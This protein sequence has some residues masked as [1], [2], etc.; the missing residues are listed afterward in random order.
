MTGMVFLPLTA[1]GGGS[2]PT[3]NVVTAA[4]SPV[5]Q[6]AP[7]GPPAPIRTSAADDGDSA[8][9]GG[10]A[11]TGEDLHLRVARHASAMQHGQ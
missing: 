10:R 3:R 5:A 1:C 6:A 2:E 11:A 7:P 4:P 9:R 8:G